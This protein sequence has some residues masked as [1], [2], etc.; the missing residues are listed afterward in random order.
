VVVLSPAEWVAQK[1]WA[2][3]KA[4]KTVARVA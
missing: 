3:L 4:D 2:A 1:I